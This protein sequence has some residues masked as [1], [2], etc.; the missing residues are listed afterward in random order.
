MNQELL[1]PE[2]VKVGWVYLIGAH[3]EIF[4]TA[5]DA[6]LK[7]VSFLP[8]QS[9]ETN[10]NP[11]IT[12][13]TMKLFLEQMHHF[14]KKDFQFLE[15]LERSYQLSDAAGR[16]I[17]AQ[18]RESVQKRVNGVRHQSRIRA[19]CSN[20][21]RECGA[22]NGLSACCEHSFYHSLDA[23]RLIGVQGDSE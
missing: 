1:K 13:H 6:D 20:C 9:A 15:E 4:V 18:M 3:L 21:G 12:R 8:V 22:K 7:S 2:D 17:L 10:T 19:I 14:Q 11:F 5:V 16:H 23:G